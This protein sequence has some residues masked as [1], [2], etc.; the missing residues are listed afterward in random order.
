MARTLHAGLRD[1]SPYFPTLERRTREPKQLA[2]YK[3]LWGWKQKRYR[4]WSYCHSQVMSLAHAL[5][6]SLAY[7]IFRNRI[8]TTNIFEYV[9]S[10]E[11]YGKMKNPRSI[12]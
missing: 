5:D 2:A 11:Q 9:Q 8:T 6:V 4:P 7:F 3:R 1:P 12:W 10:L